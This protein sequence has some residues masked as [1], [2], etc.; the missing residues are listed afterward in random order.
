MNR[1][2]SY[3]N[4]YLES[5]VLTASGPRLHLMLVEGALRFAQRA[6]EALKN[7]D[8]VETNE[9]LTRTIDIVAELLA[10]VRHAETPINKQFTAVYRYLLRTLAQAYFD[11]DA[12]KLADAQKVL[13]VERLT[14]QE[15]C[16]KAVAPP[17]SSAIAPPLN[18]P[19]VSPSVGISFQ[20]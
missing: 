20:A 7:G 11:G 9:A 17:K 4:D 14:W 5:K 3:R 19:S 16:E 8:A 10:G 13:E 18:M 1:T 6:Q 12:Q 2:D 15:A